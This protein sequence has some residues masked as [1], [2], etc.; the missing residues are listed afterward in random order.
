MLIGKTF[1]INLAT[2]KLQT[3][4]KLEKQITIA[5]FLKG[6]VGYFCITHV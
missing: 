5:G 1:A 2:Q 4:H 3:D 6:F